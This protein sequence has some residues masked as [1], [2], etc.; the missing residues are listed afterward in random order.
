MTYVEKTFGEDK[1][2]NDLTLNNAKPIINE[3]DCEEIVLKPNTINEVYNRYYA[4]L[5]STSPEKENNYEVIVWQ[6][7]HQ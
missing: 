1:K 7:V 3:N 6:P 2:M 5:K 4:T